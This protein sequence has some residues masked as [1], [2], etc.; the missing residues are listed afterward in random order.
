MLSF[1]SPIIRMVAKKAHKN[2]TEQ[3]L[4]DKYCR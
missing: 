1:L 2:G 4:L 3:W